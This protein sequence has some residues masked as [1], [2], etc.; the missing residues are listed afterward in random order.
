LLPAEQ[1]PGRIGARFPQEAASAADGGH[2]ALRETK[3][4]ILDEPTSALDFT[5]QIEVLKG[6]AIL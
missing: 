5:T 2:G 4:I 1:G 6:R 3:T